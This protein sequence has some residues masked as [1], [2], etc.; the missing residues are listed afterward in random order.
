[1]FHTGIILKAA[2]EKTRDF[3]FAEHSDGRTATVAAFFCFAVPPCCP[4]YV[5][6]L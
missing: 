5:V 6:T 3:D 4:Y 2:S 1:M